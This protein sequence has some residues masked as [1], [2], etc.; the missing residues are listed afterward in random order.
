MNGIDLSI[1]RTPQIHMTVPTAT[2]MWLISLCSFLVVLQSSLS[3]SFSSLFIALASVGT[4]VFAEW[5]I[6]VSSKR[7]TLKDGS[8][9]ASALVFTLMLPHQIHPLY[10]VFGT[11]FAILVV[12]HS[13]GGLGTNWLNPAIG[14]WLFIRFSWPKVFAEALQG[15]PLSAL[16]VELQKGIVDPAGS[17]L[18]IL[19][20]A[21]FKGSP[22]DN[23][24]TNVLNGSL[25]SRLGAQIPGGYV[26]YF[27]FS[28]SGIIADRGIG[29]LLLG[30]VLILAVGFARVWIPALFLTCYTI[31]LRIFGALPLGGT[32]GSGDMLFGLLT[33]GTLVAAFLMAVDPTTGPKSNSGAAVIVLLSA[34]AAYFFRYLGIDSYGAFLAI[35]LGN[36]FVPLIRD[37]ESRIFYGRNRRS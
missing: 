21:G 20:I 8:A 14:G 16:A 27:N 28:G 3:D 4:G 32:W 36:V 5:I 1:S 37:W 15:S 7:Y 11:L 35:A 24:V 23:M 29:I 2:R 9:V 22:T 25:F 12:K 18:G 33:G 34:M 26:D 13:F 30:T 31:L 17:P 6:G 19:K 10:A